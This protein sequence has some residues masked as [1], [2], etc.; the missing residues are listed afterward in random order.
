MIEVYYNDEFLQKVTTNEE[1]WSVAVNFLKGKGISPPY[2]RL[3]GN[4]QQM[5][6]D[7]G[8]WSDFIYFY[9]KE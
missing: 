6:M 8:S 2:Y 4:T 3:F 7:F 9:D 5:T 1:A